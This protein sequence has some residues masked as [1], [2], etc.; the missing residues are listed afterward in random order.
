MQD[1][2]VRRNCLTSRKAINILK[3]VTAMFV[4]GGGGQGGYYMFSYRTII[5]N[6]LIN[7]FKCVTAFNIKIYIHVTR[8]MNDQIDVI[9]KIDQKRYD[10]YG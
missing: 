7:T 4:V 6:I 10:T 5:Y 8:W 9:I 3:G 2:L 1:T